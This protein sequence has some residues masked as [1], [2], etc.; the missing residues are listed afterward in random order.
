MTKVKQAIRPLESLKFLIAAILGVVIALTLANVS[1]SGPV[2]TGEPLVS[3]DFIDGVQTSF[4]Y[5]VGFGSSAVGHTVDT[6]GFYAGG[7]AEP[8]VPNGH[9][10]TPLLLEHN[11]GGHIHSQGHR[12]VPHDWIRWHWVGLERRSSV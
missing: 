6:W 9:S 7:F 12:A 2:S 4:V 10:V 3:R 8:T 1:A 11:F 5:K